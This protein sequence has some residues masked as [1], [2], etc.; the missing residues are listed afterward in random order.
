[1]N[2]GFSTPLRHEEKRSI[3][4]SRCEMGVQLELMSA[5]DVY[6]VFEREKYLEVLIFSWLWMNWYISF[7]LVA[8]A[9]FWRVGMPAFLWLLFFGYVCFGMLLIKLELHLMHLFFCEAVFK[10]CFWSHWQ[11][12]L[13]KYDF[14]NVAC[15]FI[16]C[17]NLLAS[18]SALRCP[19]VL[20]LSCFW[21]SS[22][23]YCIFMF[24][25]FCFIQS[26]LDTIVNERCGCVCL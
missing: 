26:S 4:S 17:C 21:S 9:R 7:S 14:Q 12:G 13:V 6:L 16:V 8:S 3:W 5:C 24:K 19:L 20:V 1:M 10:S 11:L 22:T 23:D 18:H 15:C 25:Q 2:Q